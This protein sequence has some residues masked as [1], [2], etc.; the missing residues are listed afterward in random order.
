[1][2]AIL[3]YTTLAVGPIPPDVEKTR[4]E[5]DPRSTS[6]MRWSYARFFSCSFFLL[7]LT[8]GSIPVTLREGA[9]YPYVKKCAIPVSSPEVDCCDVKTSSILPV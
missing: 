7:A 4:G 6:L 2:E 9:K 3:L 1:M 5:K 8:E